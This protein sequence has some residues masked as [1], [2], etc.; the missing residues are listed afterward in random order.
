[1]KKKTTAVLKGR[2][3]YGHKTIN[4]PNA[5]GQL[6][7]ITVDQA[8]VHAYQLLSSRGYSGSIKLATE[9]YKQAP[10]YSEAANLVAECCLSGL[11]FAT[12]QTYI[13]KSLALEKNN[14]R[15]VDG[16]VQAVPDKW[17]T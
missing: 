14:A 5:S 2:S 6:M 15:G 3:K 16:S 12:A 1:M 8:I 10:K 11:N 7:S 17:S 4:I 9:I 13:D